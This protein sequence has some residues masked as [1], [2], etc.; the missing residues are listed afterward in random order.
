MFFGVVSSSEVEVKV[1]CLR[2]L[3]ENSRHELRNFSTGKPLSSRNQSSII[4]IS[5]IF[6][7]YASLMFFF[8]HQF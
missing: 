6:H 8:D 3:N 2:S 5:H 7:T 1:E 4:S